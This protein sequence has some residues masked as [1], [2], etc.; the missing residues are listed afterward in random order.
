MTDLSQL[1]DMGEDLENRKRKAIT[2]GTKTTIT[3]HFPVVSKT[4][5]SPTILKEGRCSNPKQDPINDKSKATVFKGSK[6]TFLCLMIDIPLDKD[7][8]ERHRIVATRLFSAIRQG[9]PTA[10]LVQ[11]E[12]KPKTSDTEKDASADLCIN[13]PIKML[14]S[15]TQLQKFF[16]KGRLKRGGGTV[17]ANI[18]IPHNEEI[19][20]NLWI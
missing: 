4:P 3:N 1:I 10:V 19:K 6:L 13:H 5:T 17:F 12:T 18:L 8:V 15:I 16:P 9:D 20:G 14:R 11:H 7:H 2:E